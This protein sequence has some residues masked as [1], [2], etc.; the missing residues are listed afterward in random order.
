MAEYIYDM[1]I[2]QLS[3]ASSDEN[4]Q[5]IFSRQIAFDVTAKLTYYSNSSGPTLSYDLAVK[6]ISTLMDISYYLRLM[7]TT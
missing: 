1:R 6:C 5:V 7:C 4:Q 3:V 2:Y